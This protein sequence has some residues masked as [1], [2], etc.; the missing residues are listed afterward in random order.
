MVV[1]GDE[2]SRLIVENVESVSSKTGRVG[3]TAPIKVLPMA[4]V[5]GGGL[6]TVANELWSDGG[7]E[8]VNKVLEAVGEKVDVKA[9]DID[10]GVDES[11]TG[12]VDVAE[13]VDSACAVDIGDKDGVVVVVVIVVDV[14][15]KGVVVRGVDDV[16]GES[17]ATG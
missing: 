15:V 6:E 2:L 4:G 13:A 5:D 9:V 8:E 10:D 3:E 1:S 12:E 11:T 17:V 7:R 16:S 14:V